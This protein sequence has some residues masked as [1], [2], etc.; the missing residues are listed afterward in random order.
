MYFFYQIQESQK[1]SAF[2][3]SEATAISINKTISIVV[4]STPDK[5]NREEIQLDSLV[6]FVTCTPDGKYFVAV[7]ENNVLLIFKFA[8]NSVVY[9]K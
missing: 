6:A 8:D 3:S 5:D 4:Y 9:T 7:L 2:S 1:I